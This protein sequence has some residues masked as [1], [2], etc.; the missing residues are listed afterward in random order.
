MQNGRYQYK[1]TML[2]SPFRPAEADAV[3]NIKGDSAWINTDVN[4]VDNNVIDVSGNV[5]RNLSNKRVAITVNQP[6]FALN[7]Q[8][9]PNP[10]NPRNP[11]PKVKKVRISITAMTEV[12]LSTKFIVSLTIYDKVGNVVK[13][14]PEDD[15]APYSPDI[16]DGNIVKN[17]S[18]VV[19]WDGTNRQGRIVGNGTYLGMLKVSYQT[20]GADQ[21]KVNEIKMI[22]VKLE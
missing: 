1:V 7:I 5:Q 20:V 13:K 4:V 6:P 14:I 8:M 12:A 22:G 11:D 19:F 2:Q 9:G 10:F 17:D 3:K 16:A 21:I 18:C 15:P